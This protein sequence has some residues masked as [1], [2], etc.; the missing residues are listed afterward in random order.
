MGNQASSGD[1]GLH[2]G[3]KGGKGELTRFT[4]NDASSQIDLG[5]VAVIE[6]GHG[7]GASEAIEPGKRARRQSSRLVI[8]RQGGYNRADRA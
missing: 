6:G 8:S 2:R 5:P 3:G 4:A 1:D 7:F